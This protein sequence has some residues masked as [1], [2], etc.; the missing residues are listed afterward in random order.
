MIDR[1][2]TAP[3]AAGVGIGRVLLATCILGGP[4]AA[5]LGFVLD[6]NGGLQVPPLDAAITNVRAEGA[7]KYQLFLLS[8]V[9]AMYLYP[10]SF[11]GLGL[12]AIRRCPRLATAGIVAGLLGTMVWGLFVAQ[13]VIGFHLARIGYQPAYQAL[14]D[15]FTTDRVVIVLLLIWIVGHLTGYL[16]LGLALARSRAVPRWAAAA[17]LLSIPLQMAAY[18]TGQGILQDIAAALVVAGSPPAALAMLRWTG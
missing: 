1:P 16:L 8:N 13:M 14:Y 3:T 5:L 6:P 10:I 7:V 9:A 4:V 2:T 11:L 12:L 18:P 15:G 17:I